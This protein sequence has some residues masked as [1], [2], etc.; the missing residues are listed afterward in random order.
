[1]QNK[2][3][4]A[5]LLASASAAPAGADPKMGAAVPGEPVLPEMSK[6]LKAM[7][8]PPD[9]AAIPLAPVKMLAKDDPLAKMTS[10]KPADPKNAAKDEKKAKMMAKVTTKG[11]AAS[12]LLPESV[13]ADNKDEKSS[14]PLLSENDARCYAARFGDLKGAAA[15]THFATIGVSQGRLGTCAKT[16]T[17]YEA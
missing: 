4:I 11:G 12:K 16:L 8:A 5:L 17:D 1:M 14:S 9:A 10:I 13:N 6:G 15:L 3:V 7:M 2:L